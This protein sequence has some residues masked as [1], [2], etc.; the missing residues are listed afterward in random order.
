MSAEKAHRKQVFINYIYIYI[1]IY[2]YTH[3]THITKISQKPDEYKT[4]M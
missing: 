1:Y 4:H 3:A 2:K